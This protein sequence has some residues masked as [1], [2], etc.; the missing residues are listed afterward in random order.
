VWR[1]SALEVGFSGEV[2]VARVSAT[3]NVVEVE[4]RQ[5][6]WSESIAM[7]WTSEHELIFT[8]FFIQSSNFIHIQIIVL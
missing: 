8:R 2:S 1:S 3:A 5:R 6:R 7:V 4:R